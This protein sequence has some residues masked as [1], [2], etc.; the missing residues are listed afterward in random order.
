MTKSA[1]IASTLAQAIR[2]QQSGRLSEAERLYRAILRVRPDHPEA[3]HNLGLLS[4][5]AGRPEQ[6]LP[7]LRAALEAQPSDPRFLALVAWADASMRGGAAYAAAVALHAAG[8]LEE[9]VAEYRRT[10]DLNPDLEDALANQGVA[11]YGLGRLE[12]AGD[13]YCRLLEIRP[14]NA[15]AANNLGNILRQ[16]GRLDE[17]ETVCRHAVEIMPDLAAGHYNLG[18]VLAGLG[19]L[20]EAMASHRRAAKAAPD[21]AEAH[22]ALADTLYKL[23]RR[24]E[25]VEAWRRVLELKPGLAEAHLNL[26]I[27]L[28]ELGRAAEALGCCLSA[29]AADE[30]RASRM[31]FVNCIRGL[32]PT[33]DDGRVRALLVRAL[34]EPW[35]MPAELIP[36]AVA[37]IRLAP[38]IEDC[39]LGARKARS[40]R[41]S[42]SELLPPS[43]IAA[44]SCDALLHAALVTAPIQDLDFERFLTSAR[45]A[46]LAAVEGTAPERKQAGDLLAFHC[47]LAQQCFITEYIHDCAV[48]E[49]EAAAALRGR[50]VAALDNDAAIPVQWLPAVASYFPLHTLPDAQRLLDRT[51]PGEARAMLV[52]QVEEPL[53]EF[54]YRPTISRLTPIDDEVSLQVAA[55]Y[56]ANPYPRWVKVS[57]IDEPRSIDD[58]LRRTFPLARFDPLDTGDGVD[59]LVAGCGTG[60]HPICTA[61]TY[62]AAR[63]LAIDLSVSSLCYAKRKAAEL[64]LDA[65]EFAQADITRLSGLDRRF[66]VI[67]A[68]GVLHHLADPMEG[69]RTLLGLLRPGGAMRIGLYS[70][71]ARRDVVRAR[72]FIA[73]GGYGSSPEEIRRCRQDLIEA[74][75]GADFASLAGF[76]DFF[77]TSPCR[78]LLFHVQEHRLT[79]EAIKRFLDANGLRF[80]GFV[81][82]R[83][84]LDSYRRR[85]PD[86]PAAT[87][88]RQWQVL[89]IENPDIFRSMYQFWVQRIGT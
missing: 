54:G 63:L 45:H 35:G 73:A 79:L 75:D 77:G 18:L 88:L 82:E 74:G 36:V 42:L 7:Y 22:Y 26:G 87:D 19:R 85:F 48:D 72:D 28:L 65:I 23:G 4:L 25:A 56:E 31:L 66:D 76:S 16:S 15:M 2:C 11:L 30:T 44:A 10:L 39:I 51:W 52:S 78:D 32:R 47:A 64:G 6:A 84:V 70:E 33:R 67:E 62:P 38:G 1:P 20:P 50:L 3:N 53:A 14:G 5:G 29:M 46:L 34:S 83:P 43:A 41:P 49:L 68:V 59:V 60:Q 24:E 89:E 57:V 17:A 12:Q 21:L 55:L 8:R 13:C 40:R 71:L 61:Q 69:W 81:V 86:D 9:A 27:T 58:V 80:M 37:M